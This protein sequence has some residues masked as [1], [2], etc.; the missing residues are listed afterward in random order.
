MPISESDPRVFFAAERTLLAW[1][2]TSLS[3]IAI[4]FVI[5]RFGLFVQLVSL[6]TPTAGL[7]AHAGIS[8]L[9]GIVFVLTGAVTA[10]I[11]MVQHR[12]FVSTLPVSDC[13]TSYSATFAIGFGALM[14]I[15]GIGLS[16]YLAIS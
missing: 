7:H 9:I 4:G 3:V 6:Q 15:L 5:A 11:A 12:G 8:T 2:R 13:P 1:L 10:L 16:I 14:G